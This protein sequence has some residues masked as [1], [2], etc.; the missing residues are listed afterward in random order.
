MATSGVEA[1]VPLAALNGKGGGMVQLAYRRGKG[2]NHPAKLT[3]TL[4]S[5]LDS[6]LYQAGMQA[7]AVAQGVKLSGR[8]ADFSTGH[9][10]V[11]NPGAHSG[12]SDEH[13]KSAELAICLSLLA[14]AAKEN[15]AF[16]ATGRVEMSNGQAVVR[17]VSG[18]SEKL[19]FLYE[20][21]SQPGRAVPPVLFL[22]RNGVGGEENLV[23]LKAELLRLEEI[24]VAAY[25]ID[26]LDEALEQ[27]DISR[28]PIAAKRKWLAFSLGSV[29][30]LAVLALGRH[31]YLQAP[32]P[33]GFGTTAYGQQL[34]VTPARLDGDNSASAAPMLPCVDEAGYFEFALGDRILVEV[35]A[36][37]EVGQLLAVSVSEDHAPKVTAISQDFFLSSRGAYRFALPTTH[38][39]ESSY[40]GFVAVRGQLD[41]AKIQTQLHGAAKASDG[42]SKALTVKS[43]LNQ[44]FS[45][46]LNYH[47]KVVEGAAE[48]CDMP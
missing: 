28:F 14:G 41:I 33:L 12:V 2:P 24:G 11:L 45:Y 21:Y 17:P 46:V 4:V 23:A 26:K 8:V 6:G 32:L 1:I 10:A 25:P 29:L 5:L 34:L 40:L 22:P 13:A 39:S 16:I 18:L 47:F 15:A 35:R 37:G 38:A 9:V 48:Q 19:T 30:L 36:D 20:F 31:Y 44:H 27:L 7:L 3:P 43:W 42:M